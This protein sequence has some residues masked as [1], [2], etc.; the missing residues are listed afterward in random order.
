VVL[1]AW[2]QRP[3]VPAAALLLA[4]LVSLLHGQP[5]PIDRPLGVTIPV[6]N[7]ATT[8]ANVGPMTLVAGG[9]LVRYDLTAGQVLPLRV[10]A[11]ARVM[12]VLPRYRAQAMLVRFPS[13]RLVAYV[14]PRAGGPVAGG[15]VAG[16]IIRLGEARGLVPD[17]DN[18]TLWLYAA[19]RV[20]QYWLDGRPVGRTVAVPRGYLPVSGVR[21]QVVVSSS[22]DQ[23]N[24]LLLP[25]AGRHRLL[26]PGQALDAAAGVVLL[27]LGDELAVLN[28]R[29]SVFQVLPPL[30]AVQ[31]TGP[32]TL[33]EDGAAFA[34]LGRVNNHAQLIV[35]PISPTSGA[36]LQ[37][38]TLD[39]GKALPYPPAAR[40]TSTGSVLVVRPD[41]RLVY[42]VPGHRNG[43][44]LD[45]RL[46]PVTGVTSG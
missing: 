15:P 10:P 1:P 37:L 38:V 31:L 34:V 5:S 7:G 21:G 26:A 14:L 35:G 4:A 8:P 46:P 9:G 41:G 33:A 44:V 36:D 27:R 29:T 40:W 30:S 28:L 43:V 12:Q 23:A 25:A 17:V 39:G 6:N 16:G 45:V 22:G 42:F 3:V 18:H 2:A 32:G 24:T 19:G 11:G 13:G 20:S